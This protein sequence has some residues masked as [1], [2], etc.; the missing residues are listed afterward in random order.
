MP[1]QEKVR[2]FDVIIGMDLL[3]KMI[4]HYSGNPATS[5]GELTIGF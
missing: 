3:G 4:F 5:Q 2:G 1:K